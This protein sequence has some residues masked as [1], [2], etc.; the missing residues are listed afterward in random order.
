MEDFG[1]MSDYLPGRGV[2]N[3]R[4][5]DKAVIWCAED[6]AVSMPQGHRKVGITTVLG[7][8]DDELYERKE[9]G[10]EFRGA[11]YKVVLI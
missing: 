10:L 6:V 11:L 9:L 3:P 2:I 4:A 1:F 7:H 5:M 8:L